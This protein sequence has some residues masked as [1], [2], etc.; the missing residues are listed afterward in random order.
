MSGHLPGTGPATCPDP[1]LL[2]SFVDG[3]LPA[4]ERNTVE[5]HLAVCGDCRDM[6]GDA[7]A[8]AQDTAQPR[9]VNRRIF[10][11]AGGVLAAA[12]AVFLVIRLQPSAYYVPE[13]RELVAAVGQARPIEPRMTGGFAYGPYAVTRGGTLNRPPLGV[14][15]AAAR[16]EARSAKTDAGSQAAL[17]IAQ[18]VTGD[19][20]AAETLEEAARRDPSDARIRSD[21]AAAYLVQ[22]RR[23]EDARLLAKA[24]DSAERA[25]AAAP[26]SPEALFNRALSLESLGLTDRARDAWDKY[27]AVDSGSPW[28]DEARRRREALGAPSRSMVDD[29]KRRLEHAAMGTA[30]VAVL[31]RLARDEAY[32][33]RQY[34]ESDLLERWAEAVTRHDPV[35]ARSTHAAATVIAAAVAAESGDRF[36]ADVW[37]HAA[38]AA[39][40]TRLAAGMLAFVRGKRE[41]DDF[42]TAA[43]DKL[44]AQ[45]EAAL[46]AA[47]SPMLAAARFHRTL[48]AYYRREY[49]A[50]SSTLDEV[51][52]TAT[53]HG[54]LSLAGQVAWRRGLISLVRGDYAA[55]LASYRASLRLFERTA[56]TDHIASVDNALAEN[57]RYLGD[58]DESWSYQ[59]KAL[60]AIARAWNPRR[61]HSILLTTARS[62]LRDQLPRGALAIQDELVANAIAWGEPAALT[63]SHLQRARSLAAL[64]QVREA[65]TELSVAREALRHI[66]DAVFARQY[67][68]ELAL[69]TGE[70]SSRVKP[71]EAIQAL[72]TADGQLNGSGA[73]LRRP[74]LLLAAGRANW[75]AGDRQAAAEAFENGIRIFEQRREKLP[76]DELRISMFDDA[77][78][79]FEEMVRLE[80][81]RGAPDRALAY[82]ERARGRMLLQAI[83]HGPMATALAPDAIRR[84]LPGH[85]AL[86][87]YSVLPDRLYSWLVSADGITFHQ[88]VQDRGALENLVRQARAEIAEP[89]VDPAASARLHDL[90]LAPVRADIRPGDLIAIVPDGP[91]NGV[92]FA[93][94]ID[95]ASRKPVIASNPIMTTISGTVFVSSRPPQSVEGGTIVIGDP[96]FDPDEF[97][98]LPR[99]P[100]ASAEAREIAA[101]YPSATVLLDAQATKAAFRTALAHAATVHFAGHALANAEYPWLSRLVFASS[102]Q[103]SALYA[104]EVPALP[105]ERVNLVVLGACATAIGAESRSEGPLSMARPFIAAGVPAVVATLWDVQD[106]ASRTLLRAFHRRV[107]AGES[108][109]SALQQAQWELASSANPALASPAA[110]AGFEIIGSVPQRPLAGPQ[111]QEA[112][113]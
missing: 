91:L 32:Q 38:H 76:E 106:A 87:Y 56:E 29:L 17:G 42:H 105:L 79:L 77:W 111:T 67:E 9:P 12:A 2:A 49:A 112:W 85:T 4:V 48:P 81:E 73:V 97:P 23:R 75:L 27:L 86:I 57:F 31:Q 36:P 45:A 5:A 13:M 7:A 104:Y 59:L 68:T 103:G 70:V 21:L 71:H 26:R 43:A 28:A 34:L 92:P 83:A 100:D 94:L 60:R 107:A 16:I 10:V 93:A 78:D 3:A 72:E 40:A 35:A 99:L 80:V 65:E 37:A 19:D 95:R 18:L 64:G 84:R 39:D 88:S 11:V 24:L 8:F 50:A 25:V 22:G 41:L 53:E 69:A 63:S 82:L 113:R 90:L 54:Y 108:P 47:G 52:A 98:P 62:S 46:A 6:I 20:R 96:R 30:D 61:R 66:P 44:F 33:T 109:V 51:Q 101:F 14:L 110:W 15:A 74:Q 1:E 58:M 102:P 89:G 55:S